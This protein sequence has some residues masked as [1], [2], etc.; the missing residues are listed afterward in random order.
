MRL[1]LLAEENLRNDIEGEDEGF[2]PDDILT[3]SEDEFIRF[4]ARYGATKRDRETQ[5]SGQRRDHRDDSSNKA[6]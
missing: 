6:A 5:K 2:Q 4:V 3:L 1:R